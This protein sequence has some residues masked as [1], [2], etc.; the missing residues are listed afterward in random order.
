MRSRVKL[1]AGDRTLSRRILRRC[2]DAGIDVPRE[3]RRVNIGRYRYGTKIEA[4]VVPEDIHDEEVARITKE[5]DRKRQE[6]RAAIRQRAIA[7]LTEKFP[8][9][10]PQTIEVLADSP[11]GIY[12]ENKVGYQFGLGT[13]TYWYNLGYRVTGKPTAIMVKGKRLYDLYDKSSLLPKKSRLSVKQ[14][15][16]QWLDKYKTKRLVLAQSIRFANRLQK[17]K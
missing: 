15:E 4:Y 17:V 6:H 2:R 8:Q 3:I 12:A 16:A 14:I 1:K 9:L 7:E 13:K 10:P 11:K 5:R